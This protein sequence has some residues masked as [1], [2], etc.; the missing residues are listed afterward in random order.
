LIRKNTSLSMP[1]AKNGTVAIKAVK[2]DE[3]CCAD[4]EEGAGELYPFEKPV[5]IQSSPKHPRFR[6]VAGVSRSLKMA[7]PDVLSRVRLCGDAFR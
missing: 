2:Y 6:S 5:Q 3:G 4:S 7:L 1:T